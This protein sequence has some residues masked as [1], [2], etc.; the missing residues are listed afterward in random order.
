GGAE[1]YVADL[2][3]ALVRAGHRVDL[4]AHTWDD[5]ALPPEVGRI[6]V[7]A[8]G[9]TRRGRI[10]AF[11]RNSAAA[12]GSRSYDCT[13]GFINTWHHD[14]LIPQGGVH[15]ASLD[16]NARRFPP[17]WRRSLYRLSK[18]A[19]PRWWAYRSIERRQYDP[20][21]GATVVAVSQ[22]VKRHL[23]RYNGV[24]GDRI[25]VI[26][27]AIDAARLAVADPQA[28]R[29]DL[30]ARHGLAADDL[31]ALFVG[32]NYWLK[33]LEPLLHALRHRRSR[34]PS[35]RPIHLLVCGG[36]KRAPFQALARRLGLEPTV[37]LIG[38]QDDVRPCYWA[39]DL[40]VQPTYYDPCSL[41][42]FEALACGLPV[43]T[44]ACNGAGE[45]I[46]PGREGFVISEPDALAPLADALDH[47]TNDVIRRAM[48]GHAARLAR[49]Q[50]FDNH[51]A[52]MT[53][54]FEEVAARKGDGGTRDQGP[55]TRH[56][57]V[58]LAGPWSLVPGPSLPPSTPR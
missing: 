17:G 29:R 7:E 25:R 38:F 13:V 2:C 56:Q 41:V 53:R 48:S 43:I 30:R 57:K 14:V 18:R 28:T 1:T 26:P 5:G 3:R 8:P 55:G 46:T 4:F 24:P 20:A 9:W 49:E 54:V 47:L 50:S 44:T 27:N 45:L 11:A 32:H 35:S 15:R 16:H 22:M 21:R 10:G 19:N 40:F 51:V 23:E 33:G 39:S 42:V 12:L 36:G 6:R 58:S 34:S 52:R 37:H 31:V